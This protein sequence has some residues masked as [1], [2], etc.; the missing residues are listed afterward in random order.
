MK[1]RP[2]AALSLIFVAGATVAEPLTIERIF[3]APDLSGPNLRSAQISPDSRRV[4]YLQGKA[5]DKD[6][7]DLW[8]FDLASRRSRLLVDSR[9]LVPQEAPLSAEEEQR[10]ERQRISSLSGIVEYQF[11]PDGKRPPL[12][13]RRRPLL[14]R[15][16]RAGRPAVRRLTETAA[17]ETDPNF[18]RAAAT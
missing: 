10:R 8:E 18:R 16:A 15:P 6:K 11:S 17:F 5:D 12:P 9:S 7:L 3:A 2:L 4:T 1:L 14:L 13:A